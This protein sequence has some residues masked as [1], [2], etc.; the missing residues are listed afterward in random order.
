[1]AYFMRHPFSGDSG[2]FADY[3]R[4]TASQHV[5]GL[6]GGFVWGLGTTFTFVPMTLVGT[7]VA[8]AIGSSNPLVAAFWG[9]FVSA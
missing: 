8:Y 3:W 2:S 5:A 9:V 6:L 1:M 4:G 7:A